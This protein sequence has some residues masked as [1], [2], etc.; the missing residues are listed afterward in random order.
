[1][2]CM[3]KMLC[4]V[5]RACLLECTCIFAVSVV[6]NEQMSWSPVHVGVY[7]PQVFLTSQ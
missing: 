4:T 7:I 3:A 2:V 1:M 6:C 5:P